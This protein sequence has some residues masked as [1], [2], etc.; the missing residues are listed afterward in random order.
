NMGHADS[1]TNCHPEPVEGL[2]LPQLQEVEEF[3]KQHD[4]PDLEANKFF[5]HYK[6]IGWKIKGI[7]PIE[8]WQAAAHKWMLNAKKWDAAAGDNSPSLGGGFRGRPGPALDAQ[9]LFKRFTQGQKIFKLIT[10]EHFDQLQLQL[11]DAVM[12]AARKERIN[13][14]TGSNQNAVL[15]LLQAYQTNKENDP[16]LIKDQE[17]LNALARRIAVI[18][19]FHQQKQSGSE[20]P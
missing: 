14:L 11:D 2:P 12:L 4:Y 15:Q 13:Q 10:G 20:I 3:F 16:L 7:T 18:H 8:D 19:H 1:K 5:N 17:T 9:E 6:A